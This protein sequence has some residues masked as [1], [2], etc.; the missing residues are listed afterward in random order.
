M[1]VAHR[2]PPLILASSSPR[3]S[4]LLRLAGFKIRIIPPTTR[5]IRKKGEPPPSLVTRLAR[6]KALSTLERSR[7]RFTRGLI[8]AAD[9]IVVS[10]DGAGFLGKPRNPAHANQMLKRLSGRTHTVYTGYTWIFFEEKKKPRIYS[11]RVRSRVSMR[12]LPPD[13]IKRYVATGEGTDKAGSYAAQGMGALFIERISGSVTNVI[14][15]PLAEVVSD[16]ETHFGCPPLS[17]LP[18]KS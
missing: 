5:E 8:L 10:P 13:L 14:G 1:A 3:R 15:L 11:R 4:E 6:E 12:K 17:W 9:T 7:K 2:F 16:L 18:K